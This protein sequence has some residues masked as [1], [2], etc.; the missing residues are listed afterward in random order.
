MFQASAGQFK[1]MVQTLWEMTS[2]CFLPSPKLRYCL[3]WAGRHPL[4]KT[5][6]RSAARAGTG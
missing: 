5:G 4:G 6:F 2:A 1:K 3:G